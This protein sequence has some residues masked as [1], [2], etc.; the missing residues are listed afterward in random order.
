MH[1]LILYSTDDGKATLQQRASSANARV[2]ARQKQRPSLHGR[3]TP[4]AGELLSSVVKQSLTAD[5]CQISHGPQ[6]DAA[7]AV[8]HP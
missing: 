1:D 4:V 8:R 7:L 6:R 3:N 5:A 2:I